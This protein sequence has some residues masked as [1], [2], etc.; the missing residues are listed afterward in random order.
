VEAVAAMA[1]AIW[2]E[3]GELGVAAVLRDL[4]ENFGLGMSW[5]LNALNFSEADLTA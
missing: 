1:A 3:D 2:S 4:K 5:P